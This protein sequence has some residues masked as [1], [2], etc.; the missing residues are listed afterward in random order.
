MGMYRCR[1]GYDS[2]NHSGWGSEG[3]HNND[4]TDAYHRFA[5]LL[6]WK[7]CAALHYSIMAV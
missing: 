6:S 3:D 5:M 1:C 2:T 7:R 4:A